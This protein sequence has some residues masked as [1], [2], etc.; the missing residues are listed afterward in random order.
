M[1]HAQQ[2]VVLQLRKVSSIVAIIRMLT[3]SGACQLGTG[4]LILECSPHTKNVGA[5][6]GSVREAHAELVGRRNELIL[7]PIYHAGA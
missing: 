3:I 2:L 6:R 1:L 4:V 7:R 5:D